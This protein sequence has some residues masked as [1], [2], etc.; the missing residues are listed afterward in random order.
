[1]LELTQ[2]SKYLK[3]TRRKSEL[4][5]AMTNVQDYPHSVEGREQD[6]YQPKERDGE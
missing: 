5:A 4:L 2:L 1:M 3:S 6:G